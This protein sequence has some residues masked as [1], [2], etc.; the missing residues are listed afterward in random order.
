[1]GVASSP[2]TKEP[3][4][5][6]SD[7]ILTTRNA[8]LG[9]LADLL[10]EQHA[11]QL[12]VVAAAGRLCSVGGNLVMAGTGEPL[13]TRDGVTTTDTLLHPTAA[14]D[15]N[16]ADK[17]G[18]PIKYL[19]RLRAEG[20]TGLYDDNVNTWL[21]E[22]GDY[23]FLVRGL[24]DTGDNRGIARALLSASYK[25]IDNLDVL[26]TVLSGIRDAGVEV[27]ITACDLSE[28]RMYVKVSCPQVAAYAPSLLRNYTSPFSG[29]RGADNPLVHAGFVI[30]ILS[31]HDDHGFELR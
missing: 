21:R 27:D 31:C 3:P 4:A 14:C 28:I 23:R 12:D 19:R 18:I 1:M 15:G 2:R 22:L 9:E 5:T 7:S 16:I 24:V 26:I 30:I 8:D 29:V 17:L 13:L 20:Q 10:E 6:V 25:I 11:R